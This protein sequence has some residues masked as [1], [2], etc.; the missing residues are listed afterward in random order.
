MRCAHPENHR[1]L[2]MEQVRHNAG[3]SICR[4]VSVLKKEFGP[5]WP[6]PDTSVDHNRRKGQ[7]GANS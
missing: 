4:L 7:C 2:M 6:S 5:Q 3:R 1:V